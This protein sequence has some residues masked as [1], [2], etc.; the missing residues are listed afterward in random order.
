[1]LENYR[2]CIYFDLSLQILLALTVFINMI[3]KL[4]TDY[5]INK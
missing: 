4:S 3:A 1:M 5:M 2:K